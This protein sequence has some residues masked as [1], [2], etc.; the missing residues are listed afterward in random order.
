M[1]SFSPEEAFDQLDM[2]REWWPILSELGSPYEH[3]PEE[4]VERVT[5]LSVLRLVKEMMTAKSDSARVS[6]AKELAYMGGL[7]PVERSVN[8]N[9]SSMGRKEAASM[10]ASSLEKYGVKVLDKETG[11][12][13]EQALGQGDQGIIEAECSTGEVEEKT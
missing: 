6:A 10:L 1:T 2:F 7:K 13:F 8:V 9:L 5:P 12:G 3:T 11:I 4:L